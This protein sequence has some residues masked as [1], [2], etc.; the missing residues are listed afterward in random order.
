MTNTTVSRL[1]QSNQ[2]GAVDALFLKLF[3]GEV[4]LEFERSTVFKDRHTVRQISGGKS[5]QFPFI[6]RAAAAYHTV[7]NWI[8]GA[9]IDHAEKVITIDDLL[10]SSTFISNIDE[11]MNHYDVRQPYSQELGRILAQT[12][13]INVA[14]CMVLAARAAN[15]ITA[16]AGGSELKHTD[17]DTSSAVLTSALFR[18]AQLL[19]E[20]Y[21]P[22][23]DRFA[24]VRPL[25]FYL[26]A[27]DTTLINKDYNG[28]GSIAE[29]KLETVAGIDLVKTNNVPSTNVATGPTKYQGDFSTTI[30]IVAN[31]RAA[32]TVKLMDLAME[33][34]YE[35]RRQGTFM[36]AKYAVGH[37]TL[38]PDCA[39]ELKTSADSSL[40]EANH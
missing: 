7:G 23:A 18:A 6:G 24:F 36:V 9:E 14:R 33:S 5:A 8:D 20:K 25:Q 29:G 12:F 13:D 27:Q 15:P 26:M 17:M 4:I 3:G 38:Q 28:K 35:I 1:G 40:T 32:A 21:V 19:D 2:A 30:G 22:S 11:A 34:E 39:I 10:V 37:D 16:R 31:K